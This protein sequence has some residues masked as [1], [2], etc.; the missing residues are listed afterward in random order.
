MS[1]IPESDEAQTH[2][3]AAKSW[4]L[5]YCKPRQERN[6]RENLAR[7]GYE[8]Y[9]PLMKV[10][11]RRRGVYRPVVEPMFPRYLFIHLDQDNDNW[12]PIRSTYGVSNLVYFGNKPAHVD[13]ELVLELMR[14]EGHDGLQQ[15]P[16]QELGPGERVRLVDG[17]MAGYEGIFEAT[18]GKE[19]VAI[20]LDLAGKHTRLNV[21]MHDLERVR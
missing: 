11:R 4:Y 21:S 14:R 13:D 16:P 20:L 3:L 7:Q 18:S 5:V 2:R 9:L 8:S 10:R 12:G 17:V 6:A 1:A 19:R 15:L